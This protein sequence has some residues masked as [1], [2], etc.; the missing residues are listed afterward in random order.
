MC[1]S[2]SY[3]KKRNLLWIER[4]DYVH[5]DWCKER[6]DSSSSNNSA[7]VHSTIKCMC[8]FFNLKYIEL[9]SSLSSTTTPNQHNKNLCLSIDREKKINMHSIKQWNWPVCC[10]DFFLSCFCYYLK[11]EIDTWL[12]NKIW[13]VCTC[14]WCLWTGTDFMRFV[15]LWLYLFIIL[16]YLVVRFSLFLRAASAVNLNWTNEKWKNHGQT[17]QQSR[18]RLGGVWKTFNQFKR[19]TR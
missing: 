5:H 2:N 15:Y 8:F 16:T 19:Y 7:R 17:D 11:K 6:C 10:Y 3:E 12:K 14:V 13:L 18:I 4:D 1:Q 9:S